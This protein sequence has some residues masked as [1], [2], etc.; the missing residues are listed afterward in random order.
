VIAQPY[1]SVFEG[2]PHGYIDEHDRFIYSLPC[3]RTGS[4][5]A[6]ASLFEM[7]FRLASTLR[8]WDAC[9]NKN[10]ADPSVH[11]A[12][13][14]EPPAHADM[15]ERILPCASL[16]FNS[17]HT[18]LAAHRSFLSEPFRLLR[19]VRFDRIIARCEQE[20]AEAQLD[21]T[22][23]AKVRWHLYAHFNTQLTLEQVAADLRIAPRALARRLAAEHTSF[24][25]IVHDV[26]MEL[27]SHHLKSS[28]LSIE[29]LAKLMG[30]SSASCLRRAVR[31]WSSDMPAEQ[32]L[33]KP[34]V[35]GA[36]ILNR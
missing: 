18:H 1:D 14:Y 22:L 7:E 21:I 31:N 34:T 32:L 28:G 13:A 23:T 11:V 4:R 2:K 10:V 19:K 15:Y 35:R 16:T 27:T 3:F 6:A 12:L 36:R 29:A 33:F 25:E 26:R 8:V 5:S 20:L 24:R 17:T 30:F 9:G